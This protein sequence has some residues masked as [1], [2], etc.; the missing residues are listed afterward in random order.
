MVECATRGV[1]CSSKFKIKAPGFFGA[2]SNLDYEVLPL[3]FLCY[4]RTAP[5]TYQ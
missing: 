2:T 3:L 5:C 1:Y 4:N